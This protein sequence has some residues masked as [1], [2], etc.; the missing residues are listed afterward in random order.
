M[1]VTDQMT[2]VITPDNVESLA[3]YIHPGSNITDRVMEFTARSSSEDLLLEVP[4]GFIEPNATIKINVGIDPPNAGTDH[5]IEIGI[6]DDSVFNSFYI[7]DSLQFPVNPACNP[8]A[9]KHDGILAAETNFNVAEATLFLRPTA[10][11]GA[12]YLPLDAGYSI[13][14]TFDNQID[15]GNAISLV[16]RGDSPNEEYRINYLVV[17]IF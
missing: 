4:L 8:R 15:L 16:M 14:A 3:T 17:E 12:C 13:T 11:Y 10:R 6:S 5:D 7:H 2:F 9:A 1:Q